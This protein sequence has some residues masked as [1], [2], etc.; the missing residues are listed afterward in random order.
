MQNER[1]RETDRQG[2]NARLNKGKYIQ[3]SGISRISHTSP[4]RE[5]PN[6]SDEANSYCPQFKPVVLFN[7]KDDLSISVTDY[8]IVDLSFD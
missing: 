8:G 3:I 4:L 1:V 7:R 6:D 2:E 5:A